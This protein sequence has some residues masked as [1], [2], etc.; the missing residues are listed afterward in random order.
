MLLRRNAAAQIC[1]IEG[2]FLDNFVIFSPFSCI[3][4]NAKK[5]VWWISGSSF[6]NTKCSDAYPDR[7]TQNGRRP[8]HLNHARPSVFPKVSWNFQHASYVSAKKS[9]IH[10]ISTKK[11]YKKKRPAVSYW[12]KSSDLIS[13]SRVISRANWVSCKIDTG[14]C[15]V[16]PKEINNVWRKRPA[17]FF[18][19]LFSLRDV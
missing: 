6:C 10:P 4:F 3:C 7:F 8:S 16:L 9:V 18:G 2:L 19:R 11:S 13:V 14:S 17:P 1:C 5:C 15:P 12:E